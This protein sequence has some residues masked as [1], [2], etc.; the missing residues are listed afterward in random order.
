MNAFDPALFEQWAELARKATDTLGL[1]AVGQAALAALGVILALKAALIAF[2]VWYAALRPEHIERVAATVRAAGGK[3]LLLGIVNFVLTLAVVALL[4]NAGPI[5]L[6]GL[7]LF[8]YLCWLIL[9][10]FAAAY[11]NVGLRLTETPEDMP[12]T[13]AAA[14]GGLVCE[15]VFTLPFFGQLIA[16]EALFKG[17]GA[18]AL[19]ML[20]RDRPRTTLIEP[21]E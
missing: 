20:N 2:A 13:K 5:A 14:L 3:C 21:A 12:L 18:T 8:A 7:I 16:L 4:L 10:A 15:G 6:A 1:A 19:V 9:T 11:I 17:L